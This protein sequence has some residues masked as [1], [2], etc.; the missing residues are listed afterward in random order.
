MLHHASIAGR[1]AKH[2][3]S[4]FHKSHN[5]FAEMGHESKKN[6]P[7][8]PPLVTNGELIVVGSHSFLNRPISA[9]LVFPLFGV[10][11]GLRVPPRT[12]ERKS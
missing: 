12:Y 5:N 1:Q 6:I 2:F 11:N 4:I 9:R 8:Y 3:D 7:K 10:S